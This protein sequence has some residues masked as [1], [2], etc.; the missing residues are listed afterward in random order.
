MTDSPAICVVGSTNMD[1]VV[2]VPSLPAPGVTAIAH[3]MQQVHGGKGANQAVAA[4]RAGASVRFIGR[5]G[6]DWFGISLRDGLESAGVNC[7]L[8]QCTADEPS[9]TAI[10]AVDDCG[11]NS[12]VVA[13]GANGRV[14]PEDI[15]EAADVLTSCSLLL[16][17]LEVKLDAVLQAARIASEAGVTVILDPAPVTREVAA[18]QCFGELLRI[19]DVIC[20]NETEASVI[21]GANVHDVDSALAAARLLRQA[22]PETVI[23]TLGQQGCVLVN[24][25]REIAVPAFPTQAIDSTAAGDAFAA[26]FAVCLQKSDNIETAARWGNAAGSLTAGRMGAQ[27]SLPVRAE[28]ECLV[29]AHKC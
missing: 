18:D 24:H 2:R 25:E 23:I 15:S 10:V 12:I 13:P 5:V 26:A 7:D 14:T 8:L 4:A 3:S 20:P 27:P 21:T 9:G 6:N 22:G 29:D 11:E 1:L 16:L 17:Q 19:A 28:I